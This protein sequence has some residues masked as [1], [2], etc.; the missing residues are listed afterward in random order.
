M[1]GLG[2]GSRSTH[3]PLETPRGAVALQAGTQLC[4]TTQPAGIRGRQRHSSLQANGHGHGHLPLLAPV[5]ILPGEEKLAEATRCPCS[6]A[7]GLQT[8]N[9]GIKCTFTADNPDLY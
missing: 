3:Q 6:S 4:A 7:F 2:N 9:R 8:Q 5:W 1:S